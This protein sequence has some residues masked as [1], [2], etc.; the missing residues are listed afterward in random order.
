M[1]RL[2]RFLLSGGTA[3][4]VE[5]LVFLSLQLAI[6]SHC[7]VF[8]QSISFACGFIVSFFLNRRW[9]FN[10]RGK[11]HAELTRYGALAAVNLVLSSIA[12]LLLTG[13]LHMHALLAKLFVMVMVA[14]WNYLIF[15]RF[16]FRARA[17][18]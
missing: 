10:S 8:D 12:I 3:A 14:A 13:Y 15:S 6:K 5:Y 1:P 18:T 2:I 11:W 7:L 9:V 16:V 4:A 17:T